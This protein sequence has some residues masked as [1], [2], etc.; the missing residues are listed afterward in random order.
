MSR[1]FTLILG[2]AFCVMLNVSPAEAENAKWFPI[3]MKAN[4]FADGVTGEAPHPSACYL[5]YREALVEPEKITDKEVQELLKKATPAGKIYAAC[6]LHYLNIARKQPAVADVG[7]KSLSTDKAPLFYRSG[8]R[9]TNTTVGEVANALVKERKFL[10]F[11]LD[12]IAKVKS[13]HGIPDSIL[14]LSSAKR[15]ESNVVGEGSRSALYGSYDEAR[16]L[17]LKTNGW[18]ITW[19]CKNGTPAGKLY[20]CFLALK[21]DSTAGIEMF[22]KLESDSTPVQYQSGCE[23]ENFTVGAIA[24]QVVQKQK[25]ADF[26]F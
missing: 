12:D 24:K 7:L 20:A 26:Q 6:L 1:I 18:E 15:L 4:E 11:A 14:K 10:N 19:L 5:A 2:A 22:R 17:P 16:H 25:F 8:C 21:I 3:L 9:G 13:T 23:V